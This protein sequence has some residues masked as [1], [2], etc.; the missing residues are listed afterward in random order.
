MSI[1]RTIFICIILTISAMFFSKDANDLA[2]TPIERMIKKVFRFFKH[3]P[4]TKKKKK[5]K[6]HY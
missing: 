1:G 4:Y 2:L 5:K 3:S 6:K